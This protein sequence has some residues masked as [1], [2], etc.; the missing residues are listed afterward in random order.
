MWRT[1]IVTAG[2]KITLRNNRMVVY[3]DTAEHHVPIEDIYSVVIDNRNASV[4]VNII[5]ALTQAGVHIIFCNEKHL[6]VSVALPLNQHFR[7]LNTLKKQLELDCGLRDTIWAETVRQKIMNQYNCL[8]LA[9]VVSDK[10]K[11]LLHLAESVEPG[12]PTNREAVA[13]KKYF[14]ALFGSTFR[15]SDDDITNAALNYGYAIMR[16][17]VCKTLTAYGFNCVIGIH[18][19]NEKDQFNLAEDIMEPFRP[20]VDLWVDNNCDN[21]LGNLTADN[22]KG[23]INLINVPVKINGKK[24]R[25]RYAIDTC[26]KSLVTCMNEGLPYSLLLPELIEIDEQFEDKDE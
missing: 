14:T 6:P 26:V 5:T 15:R 20:I 4:S 17:A 18:H 11:A 9:G 16:S 22:R 23:L 10:R 7:P 8:K 12:D 13:A 25:V 24:M 3:S 19:I 1:V 21:L 2:E